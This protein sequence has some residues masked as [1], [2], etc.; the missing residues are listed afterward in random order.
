MG[1]ATGCASYI[2]KMIEMRLVIVSECQVGGQ[3]LKGPSMKLRTS[4]RD[5][6]RISEKG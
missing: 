5:R 4:V 2:Q 6:Y 1:Q 3:I